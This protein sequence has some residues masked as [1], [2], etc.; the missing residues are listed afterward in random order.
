MHYICVISTISISSSVC[1]SSIASYRA[2]AVSSEVKHGIFDSTASL[3]ILNP[4]LFDSLPLVG[5]F[6]IKFIFPFL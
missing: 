6:I 4:S 1:I 2:F 5:V 3:L